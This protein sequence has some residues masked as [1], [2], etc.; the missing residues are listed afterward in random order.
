M[1]VVINKCFFLNLEKKFGADPSFR[2]DKN[3]KNIPKNDVIEP[4]P[5][6]CFRKNIPKNDVI[7]VLEPVNSFSTGY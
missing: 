1:Q 3:P 4:F 6:N 2:F 5:K 7:R